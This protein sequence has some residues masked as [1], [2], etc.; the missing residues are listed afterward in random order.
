[1]FLALNTWFNFTICE[2]STLRLHPGLIKTVT[3]DCSL[4]A[5]GVDSGSRISVKSSLTGIRGFTGLHRCIS[6][7]PT[8][9]NVWQVYLSPLIASV[10]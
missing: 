2:P 3:D 1:M 9:I 7:L 4:V 8:Q 5:I 6:H 10:Q